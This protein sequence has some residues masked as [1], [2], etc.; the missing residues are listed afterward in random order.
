MLES[1]DAFVMR[2]A[3]CGADARPVL[4]RGI[5]Q[6]RRCGAR[7]P[8][9]TELL[10]RLREHEATLASYQVELDAA[11]AERDRSERERARLGMPLVLRF[12]FPLLAGLWTIVSLGAGGVAM[13]A[14]MPRAQRWFGDEPGGLAGALAFI[15]V[16]AS[17]LVSMRALLVRRR[18]VR[19]A[20]PSPIVREVCPSCGAPVPVVIDMIA[21]CPFCRAEL[22]QSERDRRR[23]EIGAL[24]AVR[25][26]ELRAKSEARRAADSGGAAA[27]GVLDAIS[28]ATL[29]PLVFIAVPVA[30]S[31]FALLAVNGLFWQEPLGAHARNARDVAGIVIT[32][33]FI[34]G[35][36][37]IG[38]VIVRRRGIQR[39]S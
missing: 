32:A 21:P 24:E 11:A 39:V 33:L 30:L 22:L 31:R 36:I 20:L 2:C 19:T 6:C 3:A 15:V 4:D 8:I 16:Y 25:E 35:A 29:T 1:T 13:F 7:T 34:V 18:R 27:A 14:V 38:V 10:A 12:F 23:V 26:E 37:A 17:F 9:E 5:A 28:M